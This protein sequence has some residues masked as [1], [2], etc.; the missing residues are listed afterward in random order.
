M[1][2]WWVR[3]SLNAPTARRR[4]DKVTQ[5]NSISGHTLCY[6]TH[7]AGTRLLSV[8]PFSSLP[9]NPGLPATDSLSRRSESV[10]AG[11]STQR[12]RVPIS[13]TQNRWQL[14]RESPARAAGSTYNSH[15]IIPSEAH[16][17][18]TKAEQADS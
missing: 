3:S 5:T 17:Y 12:C 13:G 4:Y 16:H 15:Y 14:S 2:G 10:A 8:A 18:N 1:K 9:Q 7:S 6:N 11:Q